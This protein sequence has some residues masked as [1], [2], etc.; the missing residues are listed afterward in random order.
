MFEMEKLHGNQS[1]NN[2]I[3]TAKKIA[4]GKNTKKFRMNLVTRQRQLRIII[5]TTQ[6]QTPKQNHP[7]IVR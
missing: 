6:K 5:V 7:V 3:Y 2:G 1:M 4:S